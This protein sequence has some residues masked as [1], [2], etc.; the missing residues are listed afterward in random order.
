VSSYGSDD[1]KIR[2]KFGGSGKAGKVGGTTSTR[3]GG[4]A[5]S[6]AYYMP[7]LKA[8]RSI[9]EVNNVLQNIEQA[10]HGPNEYH[11]SAAMTAM[12]RRGQPHHAVHLFHGAFERYS[13]V[14]NVVA[15]NGAIAAHSRTGEWERAVALMREMRQ[16][17]GLSPDVVTYN[18]CINACAHGSQWE[19]ALALLREMKIIGLEADEVTY[20]SVIEALPPYQLSIAREVVVEAMANGHYQ[21]WNEHGIHA[22]LDF[23]R[24]NSRNEGACPSSVARAL[25]YHTLIEFAEGS[26]SITD[27]SVV[28]GTARKRSGAGGRIGGDDDGG[29]LMVAAC[30]FLMEECEPPVDVVLNHR[31]PGSFLVTKEA[32][33]RWVRRRQH[34]WGGR[35]QRER[36]R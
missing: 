2:K 18:S 17:R 32:I 11:L 4:K 29:V 26:R 7:Q 12:T 35:E 9:E 25:L 31:Q 10:G 20:N 33:E 15:Y 23:H 36:G 16:Q 22:E 13:V 19:R 30:A 14:P 5:R 34:A 27:L 1:A 24:A 28:T 6:G 8:C 21:V 3:S